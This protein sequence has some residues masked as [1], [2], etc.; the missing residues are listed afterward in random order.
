MPVG[1][2]SVSRFQSSPGPGAG[3]CCLLE[4]FGVESA[5]LRFQ[6]SP[7]PGAG[8]CL[9]CCSSV[10]SSV[11]EFQSSPGPGAGCCSTPPPAR[12]RGTPRFNPHPA[13][14]PGAA[15]RPRRYLRRRHLVSILTRPGGRVLRQP[16]DRRSD[17]H[18]GVSILTRPGGRVLRSVDAVTNG[19]VNWFQSS[20]GPG[21]GCCSG[22]HE[23]QRARVDTVSILTRPGGRVLRTCAR[24]ATSICSGFNPHPARGPGAASMPIR[25]GVPTFE[26]FNPHP[27]RGPGAA[28][29]F[30]RP[31][32]LPPSGFNPHPARG[33]GAAPVH[34]GAT[35]SRS[36]RFNPHPA[37]GPGAATRTVT[38]RRCGCLSFNPHPARGLGAADDV[39]GEA[40]GKLLFQS[41]P[42][43]GAGCCLEGRGRLD[44]APR[45]VSIL[46]RP[47][48]RVLLAPYMRPA[49]SPAEFQSSPG[50]GAGCCPHT[51][52][53]CS[54]CR[55]RFNPHPARGPGAACSMRAMPE[56]ISP[57]SILTRPG[58]RVLRPSGLPKQTADRG[59]SILTR[60]GGR[61]LRNRLAEY[62]IPPR[63]FNPHPARGPGAATY[64][65]FT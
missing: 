18:L 25:N 8:C 54:S 2:Q 13:R 51:P 52:P 64:R 48:G 28:L 49:T 65:A 19:T 56:A 42:G 35:T 22:T 40:L 15:C 60:P 43:P 63:C 14:G 5:A 45:S 31:S 23:R 37:R 11:W 50:P 16:L 20:P 9:R 62:G 33:P 39:V 44:S 34:R 53:P 30:A 47:G 10:T 12:R 27:A 61:V 57:V 17:Q 4:R 58:G 36:H 59:V 21:A 24:P 29:A 38:S 1:S 46:T 32:R 3:C 41:S 55:P 6:S 26:G 7:G